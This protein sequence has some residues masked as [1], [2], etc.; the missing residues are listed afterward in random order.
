MCPGINAIPAKFEN[1]KLI[2]SIGSKEYEL[3]IPAISSLVF[4]KQCNQFI[5]SNVFVY[6]VGEEYS[7]ILRYDGTGCVFTTSGRIICKNFLFEMPDLSN[8]YISRGGSFA[9]AGKNKFYV[10][11]LFTDGREDY[12]LSI[13]DTPISKTFQKTD[14]PI[15]LKDIAFCRSDGYPLLKLFDDDLFAVDT[16]GKPLYRII[17]ETTKTKSF[18][19]L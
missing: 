15:Y 11:E 6:L 9:P 13:E 10:V 12:I 18:I 17:G 1:S 7:V 8:Y 5:C 14:N 16:V 3:E 19:V 2:Y 4:Q